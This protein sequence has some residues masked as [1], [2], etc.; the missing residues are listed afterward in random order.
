VFWKQVVNIA[1]VI[2]GHS[3]GSPRGEYPDELIEN[4]TEA[5]DSL[6]AHPVQL[7]KMYIPS[8]L[9]PYQVIGQLVRL[10]Q[11]GQTPTDFHLHGFEEWTN[12]DLIKRLDLVKE[13]VERIEDIGLPQIHPWNGVKRESILPGELD[14]L[15]PKMNALLND[16]YEFQTA[17]VAIAGRVG[18]TPEPIRFSE[19]EKIIEIAEQV[20]QAP[21]FEEASL[22]S[23]IWSTALFEIKALTEQGTSYLINFEEIKN[24]IQRGWR[25]GI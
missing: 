23:P 8:G 17:I 9:S 14:R 21:K 19:V 12:N 22:I 25:S 7:H 5:R 2:K 10:R 11:N 4:L 18:V 24:L 13:L 3:L 1:Q 6:N 20:Y 15:V 16:V